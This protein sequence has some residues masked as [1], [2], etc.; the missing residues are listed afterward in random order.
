MVA[1][2]LAVGR[3]GNP[4]ERVL[5]DARTA[6]RGVDLA[7]RVTF[8]AQRTADQIALL[9]LAG[10]GRR[11]TPRSVVRRRITRF[12]GRP[13]PSTGGPSTASRGRR[14]GPAPP[15]ASSTR[16]RPRRPR[17]RHD[18]DRAGG[19]ARPRRSTPRRSRTGSTDRITLAIEDVKDPQYLSALRLR[20]WITFAPDRGRRLRPV[21]RH[22]RHSA[23]RWRRSAKKV[24]QA[25]GQRLVQDEGRHDHRRDAQQERLQARRRRR[26]QAAILAVLEARAAGPRSRRPS[27]RPCR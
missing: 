7:P 24:D 18:P 23:R 25:A 13:R 10:R 1:E 20:T 3:A 14:H 12:V 11:S 15:S 19:H 8:D 9:A 5:A 16:P 17:A 6:L 26:P 21:G 4:V 22:A 2:A 27:S